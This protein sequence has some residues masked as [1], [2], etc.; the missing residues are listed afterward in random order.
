MFIGDSITQGIY[1]YNVMPNTNVF[2]KDGISLNTVYTIKISFRNAQ[3]GVLD[4]VTAVKPT[5]IYL[6]FG[7]NE[8]SYSTPD[9]I[10]SRYQDLITKIRAIVPNTLIYIQSITPVSEKYE[11]TPKNETNQ[12]IDTY[13]QRLIQLSN[14]I[15]VYYLNIAEIYKDPSGKQNQIYSGGD[16]LHINLLGYQAW[17][18]YVLTHTVK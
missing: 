3:M 12:D 6:L 8:M 17:M 15:K 2:A 14:Q 18:D 11:Q 7:I 9:Q 4:A 5:K 13:N 10:A 1:G 16:G